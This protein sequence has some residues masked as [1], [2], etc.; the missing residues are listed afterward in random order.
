MMLKSLI[1]GDTDI[2]F[3]HGVLH[4]VQRVLGPDLPD[5]DSPDRAI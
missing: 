1:V 2:D 3:R 5:C 4:R